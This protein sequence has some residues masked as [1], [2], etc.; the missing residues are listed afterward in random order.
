MCVRGS[1][2]AFF[3]TYEKR[4]VSGNKK[5]KAS[6]LGFFCFFFVFTPDCEILATV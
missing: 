4:K 6:N 5:K 3:L 2:S 1:K